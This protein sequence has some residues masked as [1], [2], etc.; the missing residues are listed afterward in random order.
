MFKN[1]R[2]YTFEGDISLQ[3]DMLK[4]LAF[5]PCKA[6]QAESIGFVPLYNDRYIHELGKRQLFKLKI[7]EK[8]LPSSV[9]KELLEEKVE[10]IEYRE[11][12]KVG[13]KEKVELKDEII[14]DLL[15]RAFV[16]SSYVMGFI[17][18]SA[19]RI[20]IDQSGE[21]K[22][23]MMLDMLREA[24]GSLSVE[25]LTGNSEVLTDWLAV[26]RPEQ[27]KLDGECVLKNEDGEVIRVKQEEVDS[28]E[29]C[30]HVEIGYAVSKLAVNYDERIQFTIGDDLCLSKIKLNV[31][32]DGEV[33]DNKLDK[34]DADFA[35][36]AG[37]FDRL[38]TEFDGWF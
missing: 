11:A 4:E 12:R 22:A 17:D 7:Q 19:H 9:V 33:S 34:L 37:E 20:V 16:K 21:K 3:E 8:I 31:D 36:F 28:D 38:M 18:H 26:D 25:P 6:Q 2:I 5:T 1:A 32:T 30:A 13:R 14:F 15:P 29:V 35:L 10:D 23:E 27:I 24:L